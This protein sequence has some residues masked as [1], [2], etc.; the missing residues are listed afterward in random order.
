M[1]RDDRYSIYVQVS[2]AFSTL[3]DHGQTSLDNQLLNQL[4]YLIAKPGVVI[5]IHFQGSIDDSLSKDSTMQPMVYS[6]SGVYHVNISKHLQHLVNRVHDKSALI[7][8]VFDSENLENYYQVIPDETSIIFIKMTQAQYE[9]F[10]QTQKKYYYAHSPND[11]YGTDWQWLPMKKPFEL[12]GEDY[13][14]IIDSIKSYEQPWCLHIDC[15]AAQHNELI[16]EAVN[17]IFKHY[18][19]Y[20]RWQT[21]LTADT[22]MAMFKEDPSDDHNYTK[23][24]IR[25]AIWRHDFREKIINECG[26]YPD[27][28]ALQQQKIDMLQCKAA[29]QNI[30]EYLQVYIHHTKPVAIEKQSLH[31]AQTQKVVQ[32]YVHPIIN[33]LQKGYFFYQAQSKF[34]YISTSTLVTRLSAHIVIDSE[35]DHK[36]YP[37]ENG[38]AIEIIEAS[39]SRIV[40]YSLSNVGSVS[41]S[42]NM[43]LGGI[44]SSIQEHTQRV[45]TKLLIIESDHI[46]FTPQIDSNPSGYR[47]TA[48]NYVCHLASRIEQMVELRFQGQ[49]DT[50]GSLIHIM[51]IDE[52]DT[53]TD[54]L[55]DITEAITIML[56]N[57]HA[58]SCLVLTIS[59]PN[60]VTLCYKA[61]LHDNRLQLLRLFD[62]DLNILTQA[63]NDIYFLGNDELPSATNYKAYTSG[64][65]DEEKMQRTLN[66]ID[67]YPKHNVHIY[68]DIDETIL[69]RNITDDLLE[70]GQNVCVINK[71]VEKFYLNII[72][73]KLNNLGYT[74]QQYENIISQNVNMINFKPRLQVSAVLNPDIELPAYERYQHLLY[75]PEHVDSIQAQQCLDYAEQLLQSC[76][77]A[78]HFTLITSRQYFDTEK[79]CDYPFSMQRV[80]RELDKNINYFSPQDEA[81]R[82]SYFTNTR[83]THQSKLERI[84][85][86][87]CALPKPSQG[88]TIVFCDDNFFLEMDTNKPSIRQAITDLN[89][90]NYQV[91]IIPVYCTGYMPIKVCK[92]IEK[93]VQEDHR[94]RETPREESKPTTHSATLFQ[95]IPRHPP[96]NS[97]LY[98]DPRTE[99]GAGAGCQAGPVSDTTDTVEVPARSV[100]PPPYGDCYS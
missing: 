85:D 11:S 68:S 62:S 53:G 55:I 48:F 69:R 4:R 77:D 70:Q 20:T 36:N 65:I 97:G 84:R 2:D 44:Y 22:A 3:V 37:D 23:G 58:T 87:L 33:F 86:D 94:P 9:R 78:I 59:I 32:E 43:L 67:R 96:K 16:I 27:D 8:K 7:L 56:Q 19:A 74:Q 98:T 60:S 49:I 81:T 21:W 66:F 39:G 75:Y 79:D 91:I 57:L 40:Q 6:P 17:T 26:R 46:L 88:G 54:V 18:S 92:A 72:Q 64:S 13:L 25:R 29:I 71:A 52:I 82:F 28:A 38:A 73:A 5:N 83:I 12:N 34:Q 1:S 100:S 76:K 89:S 41:K 24:E 93:I 10:M 35:S 80:Y 42:T 14:S 31:R 61:F 50:S 47:T 95:P 15:I 63:I 51:S 45:P 90:H 99:S 30:S